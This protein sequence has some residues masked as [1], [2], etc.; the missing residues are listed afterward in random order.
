[1]RVLATAGHVDHGKSTLV[2]ALTGVDPDRLAEE[3]ARGLTIDLG[4]ASTTLP[5]GAEVGFVDVPGHIRFIKNMLAGVGAV[6]ACMLVVAATEGWKPQSEEHLRILDLLGL[7]GGVVALTMAD[8]VDEPV[9]RRA[10]ADVARHVA[11]TLLDGAEVV[12]VDGVSGRGL[13]ALRAA[14]E[15]LVAT[16]PPAADRGRP[17]LW[18]DRCFPVRGAGTVVTG[19]LTGGTLA[20]GDAVL[21]E[22]GGR[23]GRVRHLQSHGRDLDRAPPGRRLAINLSGVAHGDVGRGQ[24]VVR[25]DQ[26]HGAAVV[27]A[28]MRLVPGLGHGITRRGAFLAY[29]GSG[30]HAVQLRVLGAAGSITAGGDGLVRLRLPA[31]SPLPLVPGDRYVVRDAGRSETIG[32]GEILD[33][34]PVL[35]ASKATPDRSVARVVAERGWVDAGTLERLTG[36]AT[37]PTLG[38]WVVDPAALTEVRSRAA[39]AVA[40]AGDQGLDL[41]PVDERTRAVLQTLTGVAIKDGRAYPDAAAAAVGPAALEIL[42]ALESSPW[43]PPDMG[44][45]ARGSLRDLEREGLAVQAGSIWFAASALEAAATRVAH[46]LAASPDGVT[47]GVVRD[48]LATTR[49]HVVPLLEH[50]DATGVTRRRGVLRVAGPRLPPPA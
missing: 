40:A 30:E 28:S 8:K 25:P 47:V 22:P 27:D 21:V 42:A 19:T 1:M 34:D 44:L 36:V 12:P 7:S 9:L 29:I 3:K 39:T 45:E 31:D 6:D 50:L 15:R 46:L 48:D 23:R 2:R 26:W 18:I 37:P 38:T 4:F 20:I 43:S 11:G 5:S 14:L 33:V 16:T 17:R 41:A 24:A 35:P 49:K 10:A 13:D 32:G